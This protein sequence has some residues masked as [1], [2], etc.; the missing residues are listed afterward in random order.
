MIEKL[1]EATH[2]LRQNLSAARDRS[3]TALQNMQKAANELQGAAADVGLK[4]EARAVVTGNP[5]LPPGCAI[6]RSRSQRC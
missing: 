6:T 4:P 1:L 5:S 3:P 2:K